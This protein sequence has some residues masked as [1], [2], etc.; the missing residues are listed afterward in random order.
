M[1]KSRTKRPAAGIASSSVSQ[2]D[3]DRLKY[4]TNHKAQ[5]GTSVLTICQILLKRLGVLKRVRTDASRGG[6]WSTS[7]RG[8]E[9][10]SVQLRS[11]IEVARE[12][13]VE[14]VV[15]LVFK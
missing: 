3:H 1:M 6:S 4:M 7:H 11:S 12:L 8:A 14:A 9:S 13:P 5:N 10:V 15:A 2:Y